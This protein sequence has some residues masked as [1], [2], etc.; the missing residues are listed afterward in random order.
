MCQDLSNALSLTSSI[1]SEIM[2]CV[3]QTLSLS[4]RKGTA[5]SGSE[6][7]GIVLAPYSPGMGGG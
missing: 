4:G 7:E 6:M 2:Q 5:G 1:W 3:R